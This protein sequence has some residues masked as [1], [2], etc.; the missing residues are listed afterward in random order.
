MSPPRRNITQG[1]TQLSRTN[2]PLPRIKRQ[3]HSQR[4]PA[5]PGQVARCLESALQS[6]IASLGGGLR[7]DPFG[8]AG[9]LSFRSA[10]L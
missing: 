8:D 4:R 3:R 5:T 9:F 2:T 1:I 6:G 7:K 10:N